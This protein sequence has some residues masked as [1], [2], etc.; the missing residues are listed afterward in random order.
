MVNCRV[1]Q[2][3]REQNGQLTAVLTT[4][5]GAVERLLW[6][7]RGP[8]SPLFCPRMRFLHDACG[9]YVVAADGPVGSI[10]TST[11]LLVRVNSIF[12]ARRRALLRAE[13]PLPAAPQPMRQT[14]SLA[15]SRSTA[16]GLVAI[17]D[18]DLFP[19]AQRQGHVLRASKSAPSS[20]APVP[21]NPFYT[22]TSALPTGPYKGAPF[23]TASH[24][25][26]RGAGRLT[27]ARSSALGRGS[28]STPPVIR[29]QRPLPTQLEG[30]RSTSRTSVWTWTACVWL[31]P[32][33]ERDDRCTITSPRQQGNVSSRFQRSTARRLREAILSLELVERRRRRS[34]DPPATTLRI[35]RVCNLR[36]V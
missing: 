31:N 9:S 18:V 33:P 19:E 36:S 29:D 17:A 7:S 5:A 34:Y 1:R 20:P 10:F 22:P 15:G 24:R 25:R 3:R 32:P 2:H 35:L 13:L 27:W 14:R 21:A 23:A 26:S 11:G 30:I 8:R 6:R 12:S 28:T 4:S 16:D